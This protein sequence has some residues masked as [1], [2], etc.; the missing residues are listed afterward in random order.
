MA[1]NKNIE[2]SDTKKILLVEAMAKLFP[3]LLKWDIN[4]S[5]SFLQEVSELFGF[6][7]PNLDKNVT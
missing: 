6:H 1:K 2:K 4:A 7:F 5:Q 3:F